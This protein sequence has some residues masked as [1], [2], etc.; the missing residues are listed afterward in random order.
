MGQA[1]K[2]PSNSILRRFKFYFDVLKKTSDAYLFATDL[3]H[4]VVMISPNLAADFAL[5]GEVLADFD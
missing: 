2:I 5:P 4:P 3:Q 1:L